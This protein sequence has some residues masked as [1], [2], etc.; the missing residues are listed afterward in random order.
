MVALRDTLQESAIITECIS[1]DQEEYAELIASPLWD[2]LPMRPT[3]GIEDLEMPAVFFV[4]SYLTD[5]DTREG[6]GWK[7]G[8]V[9]SYWLD[10]GVRAKRIAAKLKA[11]GIENSAKLAAEENPIYRRDKTA[12]KGKTITTG[13]VD[14]SDVVDDEEWDDSD[15]PALKKLIVE[16]EQRFH[17][18][19]KKFKRG[20]TALLRV[21]ARNPAYPPRFALERIREG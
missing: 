1:N 7:W 11:E 19:V 10:K 2:D 15:Q 3:P 12:A 14:R 16:Y 8:R 13:K 21:R 20:S 17:S 18:K 5:I 6:R 9:V 4:I